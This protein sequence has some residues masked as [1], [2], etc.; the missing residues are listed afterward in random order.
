MSETDGQLIKVHLIDYDDDLFDVTQSTK[1][2][3]DTI[4][5]TIGA[6]LQTSQLRSKR[7]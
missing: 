7:R 3:M 6:N 4:L 5:S 1:Q 2:S